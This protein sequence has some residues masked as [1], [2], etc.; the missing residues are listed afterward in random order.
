MP[1]HGRLAGV[2]YTIGLIAFNVAFFYAWLD[3][4]RQTGDLE[5]PGIYDTVVYIISAGLKLKM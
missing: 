2:G 5:L 1:T 4:I 3:R